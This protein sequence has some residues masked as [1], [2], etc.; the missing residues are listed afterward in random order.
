MPAGNQTGA[1]AATMTNAY[2]SVTK[3][4]D[5]QPPV[6]LDLR[7]Y[8]DQA[9]RTNRQIDFA[10]SEGGIKD[11]FK[12]RSEAEFLNFFHHLLFESP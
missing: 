7:E 8:L 11:A 5:G 3:A 6:Y 1:T 9:L 4:G 10:R 2:Q 12:F